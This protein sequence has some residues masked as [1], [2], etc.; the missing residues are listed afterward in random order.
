MKYPEPILDTGS[1]SADT[2]NRYAQDAFLRQHGF[3]IHS[4]R[5]GEQPRWER[6]GRLYLQSQALR[7]A[8]TEAETTCKGN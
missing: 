6:G 4:R 5:K 3:K 2:T 7:L 8:A 1:P